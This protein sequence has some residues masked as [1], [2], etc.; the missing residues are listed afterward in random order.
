MFSQASVI[1]ST[2][3][4]G[5]RPGDSASWGVF[6]RRQTGGRSLQ[7]VDRRRPTQEA[8]PPQQEADTLNGNMVNARSVRI[9]LECILVLLFN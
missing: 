2:M 9:L 6:P 7:E 8:M 3:G 5:L 1:L 4:G